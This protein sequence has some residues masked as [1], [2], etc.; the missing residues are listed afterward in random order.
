MA[1]FRK[2]KK[3]RQPR[4][5][6][7]EIPPDTWE[8]C[9]ACDHTDIRDNFLRNLNVCPAC[10]FHRRLRSFDY[11]NF[12]IDDGTPKGCWLPLSACEIEEPLINFDE[13]DEISFKAQRWIIEECEIESLVTEE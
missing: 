10:D 2:D 6:R 13:G 5:E 8:K 9:E 4:R 12:L 1:W 7:L 3:P 11:A